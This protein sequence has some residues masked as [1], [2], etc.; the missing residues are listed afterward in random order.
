MSLTGVIVF[1]TTIMMASIIGYWV[2][3]DDDK[4]QEDYDEDY[5]IDIDSINDTFDY[6]L[7]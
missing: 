6:T 3:Q 7:E 5:T 1:S 2:T 4:D